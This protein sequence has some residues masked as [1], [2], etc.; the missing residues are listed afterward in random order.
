MTQREKASYE[1]TTT[2][3]GM[4]INLLFYLDSFFIKIP[5]L[6]IKRV[7]THR[8]GEAAVSKGMPTHQKSDVSET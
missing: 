8:K 1:I 7:P 4:T 2:T 6:G 5:P 3:E